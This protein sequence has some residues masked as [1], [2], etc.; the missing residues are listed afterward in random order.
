MTLPESIVGR[1]EYTEGDKSYTEYT[2][3]FYGNAA[4]VEN[5]D[6]YLVPASLYKEGSSA[7][8]ASIMNSQHK[9]EFGS[10]KMSPYQCTVVF[11]GSLSD[12]L[13][14]FFRHDQDTGQTYHVSSVS[15]A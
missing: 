10:E 12:K 5:V 8:L 7:E 6:Y 9:I 2:V 3:R 14:Y 15:A 4:P 11:D 1:R 13:F